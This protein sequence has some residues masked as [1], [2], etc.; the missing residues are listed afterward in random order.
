MAVPDHS[1]DPRIF[2]SARK[3]FLENG[4][5]KASLKAICEGAG[6]TTGALYKRYKG[7]EDLFSAVVDQTVKDLYEVAHARGDRDPSAMS[8]A[9]LIKA[10]DMDGPD[11]MW[12]MH[13]LYTGMT[14]LSCCSPVRME[15]GTR[16]FSTTGWRYSPGPPAPFWRR[17]SGGVSAG[18]TW[19]RR[20]CISCFP[21][22][23]PPSMSRS[24]TALTGSR[25]SSTAALSVSCSTGIRRW[26]FTWRSS[27]QRRA[28]LR[29]KS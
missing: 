16:I 9:E 27:P 29:P 6:V 23:G 7:K 1:I 20:N 15:P 22:S 4:F 24:S 10:W 28:F 12:W 25:S 13:F 8:D 17:P 5:E 2:E 21:P 14:I 26:N 3:E 19:D 11:M 18:R